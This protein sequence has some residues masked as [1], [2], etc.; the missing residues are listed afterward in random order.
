M[1]SKQIC[2]S[3]KL[4]YIF[5]II[6][7]LFISSYFY[8]KFL[9]SNPVSSKAAE[10]VSGCIY[11]NSK[12]CKD[13][14]L[15]KNCL[16]CSNRRYKC[17]VVKAKFTQEC[18]GGQPVIPVTFTM[19]TVTFKNC[20]FTLIDGSPFQLCNVRDYKILDEF[21]V[22]GWVKAFAI[23]PKESSYFELADLNTPEFPLEEDVIE[24][25]K[26]T[27]GGFFYKLPIQK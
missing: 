11:P 12:E 16:K 9:I 24:L 10:N 22:V 21:P 8:S 15:S 13:D 27:N 6:I 23:G 4:L 14:C 7:V 20:E 3:K 18:Q 1:K 19:S 2:L 5:L 26:K 25:C 17:I